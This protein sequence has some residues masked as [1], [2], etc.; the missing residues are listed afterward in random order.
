MPRIEESLGEL[1]QNQKK[2]STPNLS[3]QPVNVKPPL[4]VT[5]FK[6]RS[7]KQDNEFMDALIQKM[8]SIN[9]GQSSSSQINMLFAQQLDNLNGEEDDL[10]P[11]HILEIQNNFQDIQ[12][13]NKIYFPPIDLQNGSNRT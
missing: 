11:S 1:V 7:T 8:K 12:S 6:L 13:V 2:D 4:E 9:I 10:S 3:I 5:N